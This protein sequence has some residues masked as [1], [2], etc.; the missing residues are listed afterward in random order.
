MNYMDNLYIIG[1]VHTDSDGTSRLD[2]LLTRLSPRKIFLEISEDRAQAIL[3]ETIDDELQKHETK[4]DEWAQKGF[5]LTSKQR[6]KLLKL[7]RLKGENYGFE[8]RC[9][10]EYQQKHPEVEIKYI[11]IEGDYTGGLQELTGS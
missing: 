9:S 1:T 10:V 11:D 4:M 2:A 3:S 7:A 8:I 5:V 6:S